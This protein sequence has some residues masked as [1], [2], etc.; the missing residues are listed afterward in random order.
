MANVRPVKR[1]L[2]EGVTN[3][4]KNPINKVKNKFSNPY[5]RLTC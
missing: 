3:L 2:G 1:Y 5:D 4:K